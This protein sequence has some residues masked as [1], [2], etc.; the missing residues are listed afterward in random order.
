M[1]RAGVFRK[2][3][4]IESAEL[5][6]RDLVSNFAVLWAAGDQVSEQKRSARFA[7]SVW[8]SPGIRTLL[9]GNLAG[10]KRRQR[11]SNARLHYIADE[12]R[13][14]FQISIYTRRAGKTTV[15]LNKFI[16]R[17]HALNAHS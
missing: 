12:R 7:S 8:P 13:S 14:T 1:P 15:D 3:L 9:R 10:R 11:L 16:Q 6:A 5:F 4:P 2:G 17:S